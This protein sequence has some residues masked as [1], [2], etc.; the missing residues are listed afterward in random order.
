MPEMRPQIEAILFDVGGTLTDSL[1]ISDTLKQEKIQQIME[2]VEASSSVE[3]FSELLV[4]RAQAYRRWAKE[5]RKE[6]NEFD[7]WTRWM[8]PDQPAARVRQIAMQLNQLWRGATRRREILP[9]AKDVLVQLFRRGY[10]LG[11]VS[12]TISSVEVP[13]LL[14]ELEISGIVETVVLSCLTG[15]RKPDP[16][17]L[18]TAAAR[19]GIEPG[20]CAYVGDKRDRDLAAA[21]DAGFASAVLIDDPD[22]LAPRNEESEDA[23]A[24][25]GYRIESL[26]QV[27]EIFPQVDRQTAMHP[28]YDASFS[29]MWARHNFPHLSDFFEAAVRLGFA[30]IELNHQITSSML[31][32]FD[33]SPR[34]ISSVH[35]PCPADISV[36]D[37]KARDW[38]ISSPNEERRQ[39][40]LE[41]I[42][43]SLDLAARLRLPVIVVHAGMVSTDSVLEQR[44]RSL[45]DAG[46]SA[47]SEYRDVQTELIE[48]RRRLA[49]ACLEAVRKSLHELLDYAGAAGI[50]LGLENRYHY[51]DIPS[52]DEMGDLLALAD[53]GR[54]GFVYDVGHAQNLD[55]LGFYAHE[56]WL[57]RYSSRI[58]EVHLHDV[59][60]I[61]D[62]LAPGLGEVDFDMVA[63]YLPAAAIRTLEV[64]PANTPEQV[65]A[66]LQYLAAHDCI[67]SLTTESSL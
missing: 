61:H 13:A 23:S 48:I 59:R 57:R 16:A 30:R 26:R 62:H 38:L 21:R 19:M 17:M 11:I 65:K 64:Q 1:Q 34:T 60:G 39:H 66:G 49:P 41:A 46:L 10:R 29:T 31:E 25:A 45:F 28:A 14:R 32:N 3:A 24:T 15:V 44:L 2:L 37:L 4:S 43:R 5:N 22:G 20:R 56:D 47:S 27:L 33:L 9:E 55:R 36:D 52:L 53:A 35:E 42:K 7:F 18:L 58:L 50:R 54:L 40:G 12:N 51:Y 67:K 8:L 6:L 63:R